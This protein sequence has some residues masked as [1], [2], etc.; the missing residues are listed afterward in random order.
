MVKQAKGFWGNSRLLKSASAIALVAGGVMLPELASAQSILDDEIVVTA[1][2]REQN[3]QDVGI[4]VTAYSG[5]QLRELGFNASTDL[6]V[7]TPGL[8]VSGFGGGALQSFNIRGVGQ[9]DFAAHQEAPIALYVDETYQISNVTTRFNLF[10]I[11]RAE[12]LRGPQ[13]TLFGRNSTGGL[14]Q[15]ITAKPTQ[16]YEAFAD[17]TFGEQGRRRI[18]AAV[19]GAITDKAAF[20]L[21]FVDGKDDGLIEQAT[22][23]N[24]MRENFTAYRAQLLLEPAE[25]VSFLIK[26]QYGTQDGAGG[27]SFSLPA[28]SATDFFGYADADGDVFTG[29]DDFPSFLTSDVYDVT[30]TLKWRLSD[31]VTLTSVTNYQDIESA[32]AEDTDTSPNSAFNYVQAV[33]IQQFSQEVRVN[34]DGDRYDAVVGFFYLDANADVTVDESG[35]IFFGPGAVFGID[36]TLDTRAVAGFAQVEYNLTD[37]LSVIAGGRYNVDKKDFTLFAVDFGFPG[38]VD[39][40]KEDK[41]SWKAQLNYNVTDDVLAYAGVSRGIKSGGFNIPLTPVDTADL[42]FSGEALTSYE[43]GVKATLSETIRANAAIFYYD[44]DDYQAYNID[45]FFNALLFNADAKFHGGEIEVIATPIDGLDMLVGLSYID[46]KISEIPVSLV[47]SGEEEAPLVAKVSVNGLVRYARP[48]LGGTVSGQ[49]DFNYKG[50][51]KFNLVTS[52]A[53][54]QDSYG[55]LNARIG[56]TSGGG[57]W[58]V[59]LFG[60]NL[61]DTRYRSFAVDGTGFFGSNEDIFGPRRWFGGNI[62]ISL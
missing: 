50:D 55:V 19:G 31:N 61:T 25:D 59:A 23:R 7:Q 5:D 40:L 18:E 27:Y 45:P 38:Y 53:V 12:V 52:P 37:A 48:A 35:D 22:V 3:L 4:A 1:Q 13:G 21:S 26:G 60:K 24:S 33:D 58:S 32:Y 17:V 14:V 16:E 6:V 46:T 57:H 11:E 28:G 2:K 29:E 54:L 36:S 39:T 47:P 51:H 49:L 41:F 9:N 43:G 34:F 10:D 20:R 42:P 30:G 62:R 15:Y 44:Y 8:E 56:Y